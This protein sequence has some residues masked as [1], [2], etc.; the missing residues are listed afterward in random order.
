MS[1]DYKCCHQQITQSGL[2]CDIASIVS[3]PQVLD[4]AKICRDCEIGLIYRST[5]CKKISGSVE[6]MQQPGDMQSGI[7]YYVRTTRKI[8]LVDGTNTGLTKCSDCPNKYV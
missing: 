5:K 3:G 1:Y 6:I 2:I 7:K 8:C 4:I